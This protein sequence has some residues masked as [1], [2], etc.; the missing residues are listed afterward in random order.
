MPSTV[1]PLFNILQEIVP[2]GYIYSLSLPFFSFFV[3]ILA[4]MIAVCHTGLWRDVYSFFPDS[5]F[6]LFVGWILFLSLQL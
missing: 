3:F 6:Q 2:T 5:S 1:I 4:E